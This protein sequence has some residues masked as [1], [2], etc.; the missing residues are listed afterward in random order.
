MTS[1][2]SFLLAPFLVAASAPTDEDPCPQPLHQPGAGQFLVAAHHM[3]DPRFRETV[4]LILEHSEDGSLGV[5]LNRGTTVALEEAL[6]KVSGIAGRRDTISNG[7]PVA[8]RVVI[9][10][11][12]H[13]EAPPESGP[14]MQGVYYSASQVTLEQMLEQGKTSDELRLFSGHAGWGAGQLEGELR[15]GDWHLLPARTDQVFGAA[16]PGLWSRLMR[17]MPG[18]GLQARSDQTLGHDLEHV[19]RQAAAA[20]NA[21]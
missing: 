18:P 7:G 20:G 1:I 15:R 12:R 17:C 14:V 4:I 16:D 8:R 19:T 2:F 9:F 5:I 6:P 3:A 13:G 10:L 11:V 21:L